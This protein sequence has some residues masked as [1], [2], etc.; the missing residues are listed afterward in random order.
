VR[1]NSGTALTDCT[2]LSAIDS[3]I[4]NNAGH[5]LDSFF[6][7][8][9]LTRSTIVDNGGH[10]I[11]CG[12]SCDVYP[13]NGVRNVKAVDSEISRNGEA[14]IDV[15][16]ESGRVQLIGTTVADNGAA[17]ARLLGGSF[18]AKS[19]QITG[20][21]AAGIEI[22]N[23]DPEQA[24]KIFVLDSTV[25]SNALHGIEC[26]STDR[27]STTVQRSSVTANG[28]DVTCGA[29]VPCADLAAT[30]EPRLAGGAACGTSYVTGSG[31]PGQSW[32]ICSLD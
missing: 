15:D 6:G 21:G 12:T 17:G 4:S 3:D 20:N 14:G 11:G 9:R 16:V 32:A 13:L 18:R 10:G 7:K 30:E 23:N 5:G 28:T 22:V 2:S 27:A 19:S 26:A 8:V 1:N 31:I 29:G 24:C 25:A